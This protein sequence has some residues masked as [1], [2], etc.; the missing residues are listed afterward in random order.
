[1]PDFVG[2]GAESL[3]VDSHR[4]SHYTA[5]FTGLLIRMKGF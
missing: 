2:K 1:M 5:D 3:P 4:H